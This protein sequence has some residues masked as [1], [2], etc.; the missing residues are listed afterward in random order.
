MKCKFESPFKLMPNNL[1]FG[2]DLYVYTA[3]LNNNKDFFSFAN[4]SIVKYKYKQ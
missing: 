4:K 2:C 3:G 1:G